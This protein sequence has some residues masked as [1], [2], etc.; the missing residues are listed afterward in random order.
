M[1]ISPF[2]IM[3]WSLLS[4][5]GLSEILYQQCV[6]TL[7]YIELYPMARVLDTFISPRSIN[8]KGA[9]LHLPLRQ[10]VVA[11]APDPEYRYPGMFGTTEKHAQNVCTVPV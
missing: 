10:E 1:V 6:E 3:P 9:Q 2:L 4:P 5:Y 7:W 11:A 8:I